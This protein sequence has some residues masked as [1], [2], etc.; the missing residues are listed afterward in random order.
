MCGAITSRFFEF[1]PG[2]T[3]EQAKARRAHIKKSGELSPQKIQSPVI[4]LKKSCALFVE[5]PTGVLEP[6][7]LRP[8]CCAQF[9]RFVSAFAFEVEDQRDVA[10]E[11]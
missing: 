8:M 2:L 6:I 3:P 5:V 4:V 11:S 7:Q 10:G 1:G 9:H